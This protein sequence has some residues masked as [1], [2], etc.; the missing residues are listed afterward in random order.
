MRTQQASLTCRFLGAVLTRDRHK[1]ADRQGERD[2][3]KTSETGKKERNGNKNS[4]IIKHRRK[5]IRR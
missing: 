4:R 5:E 2:R 3:K 1:E